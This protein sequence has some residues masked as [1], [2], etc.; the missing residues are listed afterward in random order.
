[1]AEV[2]EKATLG[3][4]GGHVE[5]VQRSFSSDTSLTESKGADHGHKT[6]AAEEG[7]HHDRPQRLVDCFLVIRN[8]AIVEKV[9]SG[10]ED[11]LVPDGVECVGEP[12]KQQNVEFSCWSS[13]LSY[14]PPFLSLLLFFFPFSQ[15]LCLCTLSC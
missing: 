8:G 3:P 11:V 6:G 5:A 14:T 9:E 10:A 4:E 2:G 12:P 1:M 15:R 7:R 13:M